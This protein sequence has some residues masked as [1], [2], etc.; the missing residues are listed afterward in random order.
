VRRRRRTDNEEPKN[1]AIE[2]AIDGLDASPVGRI[3]ILCLT[4]DARDE[5]LATPRQ[6]R[7][8]GVAIAIAKRIEKLLNIARSN[9]AHAGRDQVRPR[10]E[11]VR[12]CDF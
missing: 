3:A 1:T 7:G 8:Y 9:D 11:F 5:R 4:T 6:V 12:T 2:I 10:V